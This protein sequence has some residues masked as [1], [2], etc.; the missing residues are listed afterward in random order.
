MQFIKR[1]VV[2]TNIYMALGTVLAT[3]GTAAT[4]KLQLPPMFYVFVFMGTLT[5][6]SWHWY[7]TPTTT[8]VRDRENWSVVNSKILLV[9]AILGTIGAIVTV[10]QI[11]TTYYVPI[12]IAASIAGL[13]TA[14]KLPLPMF[15]NLRKVVFA[16][17]LYL[18]I[19]V[20]FVTVLLPL[21]V[22]NTP[23]IAGTKAYIIHRFALIFA[24]CIL[25]DVKDKQ[26]DMQGGIKNILN[27]LSM[28]LTSV[29]TQVFI[30]LSIVGC[31]NTIGCYSSVIVALQF[32]PI[33]LLMVLVNRAIAE[34]NNE[35]LFYIYLDGLLFINGLIL[36]LLQ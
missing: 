32:I 22:A 28:P 29:I 8:H 10:L 34:P 31:V 16:K 7:F 3:Y 21:L 33:I 13:Y 12:A 19:G 4:F 36:I 27:L 15:K 2:F 14:P 35:V 30:A 6:Y 26:A 18:A 1:I 24:I 5:S 25:F 17:T 23:W 9:C 20:T 11:P